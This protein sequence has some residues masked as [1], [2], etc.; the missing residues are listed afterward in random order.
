MQ[1]RKVRKG[2]I[3]TKRLSLRVPLRLSAFAR[4]VLIFSQLLSLGERVA[5]P[6]ARE[7]QVRG[8]FV[9]LPDLIA[10]ERAITLS[11]VL[12]PYRFPPLVQDERR[13]A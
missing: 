10:Q 13:E 8:W 11:T 4:T 3:Q 1:S 12:L 2:R 7:S 9:T 6:Q 5:I